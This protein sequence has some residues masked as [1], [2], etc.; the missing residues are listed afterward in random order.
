[1]TIHLASANGFRT[2][3][4]SPNFELTIQPLRQSPGWQQLAVLWDDTRFQIFLGSHLLAFGPPPD[5]KLQAIR[6][7]SEPGSSQR[8]NPQAEGAFWFDDL[9]LSGL[10]RQMESANVFALERQSQAVL[11]NGDVIYGRVE[12]INSHTV[13]MQGAFGKTALPWNRLRRVGLG[14]AAANPSASAPDRTLTGWHAAVQFRRY[15]DHPYQPPDQISAVVISAD[16]E[17]LTLDHAWLGKF[18]IP[19]EQLDELRPRFFGISLVLTF[20]VLHLGNQVEPTFRAKQ[21]LGHQYEG[22]FQFPSQE[23]PPEPFP[24]PPRGSAFLRLDVAELEPAG[25]GTPPGSRFLSELRNGQLGTQVSL[26][27]RLLGRLNDHIS[28]RS[29]LKPTQSIRLP[30]PEGVLKAGQN[31]WRLEQAPLRNKPREFDD[32]EIGPVILEIEQK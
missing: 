29:L 6:L 28:Q 4:S 8:Q 30:L 14:S 13:G 27:G 23:H 9:Q 12:D 19:I 32:C 26:N 10:S 20:D 7:F 18:K 16:A 25:P 5:A 1:M 2:A 17:T 24:L 3:S 21:P 15:A 11:A 31:I 22:E